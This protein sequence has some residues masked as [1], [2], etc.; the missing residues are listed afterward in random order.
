MLYATSQQNNTLNSFQKAHVKSAEVLLTSLQ[1]LQSSPL[2]INK[3][4]ADRKHIRIFAEENEDESNES[5]VLKKKTATQ[6]NNYFTTFYDY[7]SRYFCH[8]IEKCSPFYEYFTY[9][10]SYRYIVFQVIRL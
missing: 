2:R 5:I 10:S 6:S 7:T 4:G 1:N 8:C 9:I 3:P